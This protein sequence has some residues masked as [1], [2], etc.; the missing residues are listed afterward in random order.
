MKQTNYM[1]FVTAIVAAEQYGVPLYTSVIA[2]RLAKVFSL[3]FDK[4]RKL[5]NVYLKRLADSG[6]IARLKKGV[7]GR[8]KATVFGV[9][10]PARDEII[11]DSLLNE[12]D[13]TIGYE[14][15]AAF[16]NRIGLSTLLPRELQITTNRFRAKIPAGIGIKIKRPFV[17]VTTENAPYLQMLELLR[18]IRLYSIDAGNPEL[19]IRAAI[20]ERGLDPT[21]LVRYASAYLKAEELQNAVAIIFGR[22]AEHEAS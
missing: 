12:R 7:Y 21:E 3:D 4:A 20:K 13:E 16:I 17:R 22:L 1:E 9:A 2:E 14:T 11:A 10:V 5:A 19:L 6:M 18:D 15:G 8:A